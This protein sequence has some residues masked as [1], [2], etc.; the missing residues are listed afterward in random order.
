MSYYSPQLL[1]IA[2]IVHQLLFI[3]NLFFFELRFIES[4]GSDQ[5][6]RYALSKLL[7][8]GTVAKYESEFLML[9]KQ[10]TGISESLLKLF[11]IYGLK[12]AQQCALL[13]SNPT[14]LSEAFSSARA[15]EPR[16]AEDTLSKLLQR[17]TV[18]E[19]QN[20]FEML[21]RQVTGKSES[22]LTTIYISRLKV[23]LQI[24]LLRA[25]PTPLGEAFSLACIIEACLEA[26]V[27]EEK[28]TAK[29]E[30][31]IKETAY[32]I[33]SL[34]SKVVSLKEKGSLDANKEIKKDHTLVHELE[35]QEEKL[36]MELQLKNNFREA[37]ETMSKDL[38]KMMLD[39]NPTLHDLQKVVV[40]QKKKHYKTK[41]AL[42]IVDEEFKKVKFEATTKIRKL[43]KVYGA[44]LPPWLASR[45]VVYQPYVKNN[46]K[47][48][49][50]IQGRIW[51]P[52]IKRISRHHLEDKVVVKE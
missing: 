41:H 35:K 10:V 16:F 17:G 47:E 23:A 32:T 36:L 14:T 34:Q 5:D 4:D 1:F 45:L 33:T 9:I 52:E 51:D 48:F 28:E 7:Q 19:Y 25:R 42:N 39:L 40:D 3:K 20:E 2:I 11:Y 29:K 37:L 22:L 21:I 38:E 12:P 18:A 30:Q 50:F 24:E 15:T 31:S 43:A 49:M 6:A 26:I 46:W 8:T 44:W 27:H 13:R